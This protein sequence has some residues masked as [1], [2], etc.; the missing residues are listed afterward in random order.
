MKTNK[1]PSKHAQQQKI[2]IALRS[3]LNQNLI[4]LC[5][6]PLFKFPEVFCHAQ[7]NGIKASLASVIECI[8]NR[9]LHNGGVQYFHPHPHTTGVKP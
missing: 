7:F 4:I 5:V 6:I 8:C 2:T 1:K 9:N 3:R